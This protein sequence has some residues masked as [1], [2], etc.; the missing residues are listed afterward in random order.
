MRHLSLFTLLH[1]SSSYCAFLFLSHFRY[2]GVVGPYT[3]TEQG[4][5]Q[6]P[7]EIRTKRAQPCEDMPFLGA[8]QKELCNQVMNRIFIWG[9][10]KLT[11]FIYTWMHRL[12][13]TSTIFNLGIKMV[14]W[15]NKKLMNEEK[16][17]SLLLQMHIWL[18]N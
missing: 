4:I 11:F 13:G 18:L 17:N 1:Q 3:G 9:V 7:K 8:R 2:L 14:L 15:K 10:G 16:K 6:K 12:S 5:V